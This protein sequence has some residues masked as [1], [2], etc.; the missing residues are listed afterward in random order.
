MELQGKAIVITGA[1]QGLGQKMA[2]IV[3]GQGANLALVDLDHAKLQA[4]VRLCAKAGG[5]IKDYPA[6]VTDEPAVEG[7]FNSVHKDFGHVDGLINNA[8]I[9]SDA[10]L[11]KV[12]DGKVQRKRSRTEFHRV[13]RLTSEA[14]SFAPARP[15]CT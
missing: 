9:T 2:E 3:G 7:L 13:M 4:T 5:K 1:A 10:L 14:C 8:G 6:D 11:V 15:P 12:A